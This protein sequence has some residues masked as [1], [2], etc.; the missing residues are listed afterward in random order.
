MTGNLKKTLDR[1][2]RLITVSN[3]IR[4]ELIDDLG[5]PAEKIQTTYL[6]VDPAFRPR[7]ADQTD[8]VLKKY[9]LRHRSYLLFVGTLEPRKGID[10]LLQAWTMLASPVREN[11]TLVLAGASGWHNAD[12]LAQMEALQARGEVRWLRYVPIDDLPQLY[13][14]AAAFAYPSLYEGFGLPVLEAMASGVP[15]VCTAD[16]SM[17]E[18][19]E[20]APLLFER[21]NAD[22]LSENLSMLLED[23][24]LHQKHAQ[25]GV[26]RARKLNWRRFAEETLEVYRSIA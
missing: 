22:Q 8:S 6:G 4:Q 16:T 20:A 12:I 23:S 11:Y 19:A 18:F 1:A 3:V 2:D 24:D 26:E 25:L 10:L 13:A 7:P 15:V 9:G 5:V 21:G 14:G 17:A